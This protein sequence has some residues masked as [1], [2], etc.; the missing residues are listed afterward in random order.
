MGRE[1]GA[2]L[3]TVDGNQ[4]MPQTATAVAEETQSGRI[5]PADPGIEA[6][7]QEM[8]QLATKSAEGESSGSDALL[9]SGEGAAASDQTDAELEELESLLASADEASG[10]D[11]PASDL[12]ADSSPA[13]AAETAASAVDEEAEALVAE[14]EIAV[15]DASMSSREDSPASAEVSGASEDSSANPW[16]AEVAEL[17]SQWAQGEAADD[18]PVAKQGNGH[19]DASTAQDAPVAG[20]GDHSAD[21]AANRAWFARSTAI[22]LKPFHHALAVLVFVL[23]LV[24]APFG[25]MGPRLKNLVGYLA[26]ATFLTA[27]ALWAVGPHLRPPYP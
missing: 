23:V 25:W 3:S 27:V 11:I 18:R 22:L 1:G 8:E 10:I 19:A 4:V 9:A 13:G 15:T 12:P 24:D 5:P 6:I 14:S 16:A 26:I 21:S 7:L 20:T 2:S 17:E